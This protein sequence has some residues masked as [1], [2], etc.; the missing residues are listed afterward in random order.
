MV[1]AQQAKLRGNG[2]LYLQQELGLGIYC[3]GIRYDGNPSAFIVGIAI[4]TRLPRT[5]LYKY[6][7]SVTHRLGGRIWH[8]G[9]ASFEGF[10]LFGNTYTHTCSFCPGLTCIS[11]PN[12]PEDL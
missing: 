9:H 11:A 1:S 5:C 7:V 6:C 10:D 8:Q 2:L 3:H 4:T 12:I